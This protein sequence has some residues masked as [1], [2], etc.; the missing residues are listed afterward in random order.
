MNVCADANPVE[1]LITKLPVVGVAH[2][3]VPERFVLGV[4]TQN[5]VEVY[6]VP[7]VIVQEVGLPVPVVIVP[8]ISVLLA[9]SEGAVPQV[10][11]D[12]AAPLD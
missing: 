9:P 11:T 10:P 2:H 12:G 6:A 1:K 4:T 7:K 3:C 5:G 8:R